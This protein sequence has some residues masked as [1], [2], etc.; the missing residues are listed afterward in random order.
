MT[1]EEWFFD[2]YA[3]FIHPKDVIDSE[4]RFSSVMV[5][6]M[7]KKAFEAGYDQGWADFKVI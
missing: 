6:S 3:G 4:G 1:F 2:T 5:S 7:L